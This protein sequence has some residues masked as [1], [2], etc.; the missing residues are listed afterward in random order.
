MRHIVII[1][2]SIIVDT[3][4]SERGRAWILIG[5]RLRVMC[6]SLLPGCIQS[7]G[8]ASFELSYSLLVVTSV[9]ITVAFE[10]E[11]VLCPVLAYSVAFALMYTKGSS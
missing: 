10:K 5:A 1:V 8:T 3:S 6:A 9:I 2:P 4:I 11:Y 7:G